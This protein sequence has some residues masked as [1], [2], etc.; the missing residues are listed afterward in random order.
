VWVTHAYGAAGVLADMI[1]E[2]LGRGEMKDEDAEI[3]RALD[4]LRFAGQDVVRE[5]LGTY[6]DIYNRKK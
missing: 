5:A 2:E 1:L 3:R 6:N 4:P